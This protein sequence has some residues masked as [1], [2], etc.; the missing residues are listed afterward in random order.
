MCSDSPASLGFDVW[1]IEVGCPMK[2][3]EAV[4]EYTGPSPLRRDQ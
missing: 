1:E 2:V 4:V 3:A